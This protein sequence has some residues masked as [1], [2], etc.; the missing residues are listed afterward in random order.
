MTNKAIEK[1]KCKK[2]K[3]P[4]MPYSTFEKLCIPCAIKVGRSNRE[5][6]ERKETRARKTALKTKSDWIKD[7]QKSFNAYIR[8]RDKNEP[9]ISCGRTKEE[10]DPTEGWK[11]G[12]SWDCG[13]FLTVGAF[14][15]L[16]FEPLNAHKQCKSCNGGSGK[17]A[18]KNKTVGTYYRERLVQKIG[19][20][21]V[22][23]L[24]GPHEPAKYSIDDI[25]EITKEYKLKLK[26]L[27]Q[28]PD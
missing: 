6:K 18:S 21:K 13:H 5:K 27:K 19:L 28:L 10:V 7:A 2:C 20:A 12:G 16:R 22:E 11:V 23:W 1:P 17:Y 15:E 9:C 3:D 25:K 26:E 8:E 4:F 24:E 14:P